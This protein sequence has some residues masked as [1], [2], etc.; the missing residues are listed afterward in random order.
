MTSEGRNVLP[1]REGRV[2][3]S[4]HHGGGNRSTLDA[5]TVP[6]GLHEPRHERNL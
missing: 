2:H 3:G 5:R 1:Q 4:D 6:I